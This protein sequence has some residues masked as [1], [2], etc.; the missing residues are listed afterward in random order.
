[1]KFVRHLTCALFLASLSFPIGQALADGSSPDPQ[2]EY[3]QK[4]RAL[5]WV[6]GPKDLPALGNAT[7]S[8]PG[9]FL[10][11]PPSDTRDFM[12]LNENPPPATEE[13]L[14]APKDLHWYALIA[15]SPDGYVK[16]DEKIDADAVLSSIREGTEADNAERRKKGWSEVQI[17][18][19]RRAP[20]YDAETKRLEWALNATSGGQEV[21]NFLTKVLGRRGV[22]TAVLVT[23]PEHFD[24]DV[25]EFKQALAHYTFNAG[26]KYD[27]FKPGDKVA[28]YGLAALIA[29]GAAAAATKVGLWKWLGAALVATWKFIWIPLAAGAAGISRFFKRT[30]RRKTDA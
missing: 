10:F 13:Q 23:G 4:L 21:V 11:L 5:N 3:V 17:T 7:L 8:L 2:A 28:S 1:M 20:H 27:E 6:E 19:W 16:D 25:Q 18:G 29:G 26:E 12:V 14:F 24:Q 30:L 22:T 9:D 15:F